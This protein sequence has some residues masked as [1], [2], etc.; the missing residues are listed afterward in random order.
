MKLATMEARVRQIVSGVQTALDAKKVE[1]E[2]A[3]VLQRIVALE[4]SVG[5][6]VNS[7][8]DKLKES[9][10]DETLAEIETLVK[11]FQ[12]KIQ[13]EI[14]VLPLHC[15]YQSDP[16]VYAHFEFGHRCVGD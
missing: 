13:E 11:S 5:E 9:P 15:Q 12:E 6:A 16:T 2:T 7:T 8:P 4:T 3:E 1:G 14:K 10:T